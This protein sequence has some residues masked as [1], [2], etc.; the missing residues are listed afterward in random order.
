MRGTD[1]HETKQNAT[2]NSLTNKS[3]IYRNQLSKLFSFCSINLIFYIDLDKD[4]L[5]TDSLQSVMQNIWT[6]RG[7]I[8]NKVLISEQSL[9][10][11]PDQCEV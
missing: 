8:L 3:R 2:G 10:R 5:S 7:E 11:L 4:L 1:V 6:L 9:K